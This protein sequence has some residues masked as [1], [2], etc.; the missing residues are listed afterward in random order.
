MVNF[1]SSVNRWQI[2]VWLNNSHTYSII[3]SNKSHITFLY[4][5]WI[6]NPMRYTGNIILPCSMTHHISNT[7][8]KLLASCAYFLFKTLKLKNKIIFCLL[9]SKLCLLSINKLKINIVQNGSINRAI[10]WKFHTESHYTFW[11]NSNMTSFK[12]CI[13]YD[14]SL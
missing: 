2:W 13:A 5:Y 10:T 9:Y 7:L 3:H 14:F 1:S 8:Y 12:T 11:F 6:L 4:V